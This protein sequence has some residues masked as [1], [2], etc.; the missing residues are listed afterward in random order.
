MRKALGFLLFIVG[1]YMLVAPQSLL[2]LKELKWMA[3]QSFPGEILVGIVIVS[4]AYYLLDLKPGKG[5]A[6]ASH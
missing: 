1:S 3:K 2:G 5:A 6:K 4:L